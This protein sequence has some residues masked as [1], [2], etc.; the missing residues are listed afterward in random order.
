MDLI[1]KEQV[2][3]SNKK[4]I[5]I[6]IGVLLLIAIVVGALM[7]FKSSGELSPTGN[8]GENN[9]TG[10][11]SDGQG[12]KTYVP[13][14]GDV[15]IPGTTSQADSG[16]AIPTEVKEVG[17]NDV[18]ERDFNIVIDKDMVSPQKVIV[19]LLDIVT[20]NFSAVDKSYDMAQPDNGLSWTVPMGG[21]KS[22]QFQGSTPG[23]FTFYCVSCG[24]PDKGPVGYIVVV[25]R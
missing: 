9:A 4:M 15:Q 14:S 20:I 5:F 21:S 10:T 7:F 2:S 22:L 11:I 13:V 16:I 8:N 17:T 23:Q 24:G 12:S 1:P 3:T 19:K 18:S 6:G 25:P